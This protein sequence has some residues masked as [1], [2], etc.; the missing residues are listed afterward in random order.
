MA[1][2][3]KF[4]LALVLVAVL[5]LPIAGCEGQSKE[6]AAAATNAVTNNRKREQTEDAKAGQQ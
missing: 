4:S 5:L 6:E 2:K 1:S 3:L